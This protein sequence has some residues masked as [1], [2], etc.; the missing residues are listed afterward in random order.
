[1]KSE[2]NIRSER[3]SDVDAIGELIRSA[4]LGMPYA[5]GDEAE[6]V[7]VLRAQDALSVSLVAE[8]EGTLVGHV[9]ISPARSAGM[10]LAHWPF[11]QLI[12]AVA[13]AP[14]WFTPE[15]KRFQNLVREAAS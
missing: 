8:R 15:W 6:L 4:F 11:F 7:E 10:H 14:R 9:A 12:N 1:M 3:S 5:D 13:S 2:T